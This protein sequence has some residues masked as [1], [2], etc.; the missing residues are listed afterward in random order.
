MAA[1]Q[2]AKPACLHCSED[3][4]ARGLCATH[5]AVADRLVRAGRTTWK[6]LERKGLAKPTLPRKCS[7][8]F[9]KMLSAVTRKPA[10]PKSRTR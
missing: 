1:K 6:A 8:A 3:A 10:S 7:D 9:H 5:Y 2:E 4:R